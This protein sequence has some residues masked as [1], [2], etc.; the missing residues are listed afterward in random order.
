MICDPHKLA[1][2]MWVICIIFNHLKVAPF[3]STLFV[4]CYLFVATLTVMWTPQVLSP[5]YLSSSYESSV[6]YMVNIIL[7]LKPAYTACSA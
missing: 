6:E 7:S 5:L 1:T 2:Q 3:T 4:S